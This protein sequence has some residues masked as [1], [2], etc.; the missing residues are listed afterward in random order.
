MQQPIVI[1]QVPDKTNKDYAAEK[2]GKDHAD[3][4]II[5]FFIKIEGESYLSFN[6]DQKNYQMILKKEPSI[7]QRT[8]K[9]NKRKKMYVYTIINI[10]RFSLLLCEKTLAL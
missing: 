10:L 4:T 7:N 2:M 5:E 8:K 6:R 1:V 9:K 3:N